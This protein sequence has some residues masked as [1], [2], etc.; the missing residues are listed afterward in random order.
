MTKY[1]FYV[2]FL[3][4]IKNIICNNDN[5]SIHIFN[6][7]LNS[8]FI[9]SIIDEEKNLYIMTGESFNSNVKEQNKI[10]KR[11]ILKYDSNLD[12]IVNNSFLSNF[13]YDISEIISF[14]NT[15][16]LISTSSS[17]EL[18]DI[19]N[20]SIV[21][22]ISINNLLGKRTYLKLLKDNIYLF[23][24]IEN[25]NN[26]K[27]LM[28]NYITL[29]LNNKT[30]NTNKINTN[31]KTS[32]LVL[33]CDTTKESQYIFCVYI[34]ENY[35]LE[36][37]SF[38]IQYQ[39]R[40][41]KKLEDKNK[42]NESNFIKIVYLKEPN[43]FII[44][45]SI[46]ETY[47]RL[48]YFKYKDN[49]FLN[50]LSFIT[51]NENDFLDENLTQLSSY[52]Y[53]NDIITIN[54]S[55]IFKISS[56]SNM[57]RISIYQFDNDDLL[58]SIKTYNYKDYNLV[59]FKNI[60]LS[61]FNNIILV[62]F[63][64]LISNEEKTGYFFI[65]YPKLK[66]FNITDKND[67]IPINKLI[68]I[69]NNLFKFNPKI[70]IIQIPEGF[71]LNNSFNEEIKNGSYLE[72]NDSIKFIEYKKIKNNFN[73]TNNIYNLKFE[74]I[75]K[76][77]ISNSDKEEIYPINSKKIM[78]DSEIIIN[79][80]EGTLRINI[81]E[82]NNKIYPI[83]GIDDVCTKIKRSGYYLDLN[84]NKFMKCY[85][86]CQECTGQYND[87]N[88][89]C[90]ICKI[91]YIM[92]SDKNSCYSETPDNYYLDNENNI[93]KRCHESCLRCF[94]D[95]N[96]SCTKCH[97]DFKLMISNYSCVNIT[98]ES[99]VI[100]KKE[101]LSFSLIFITIFIISIII[102]LILVIRPLHAIEIEVS[103]YSFLGNKDENVNEKEKI[104][105]SKELEMNILGFDVY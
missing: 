2:F 100:H 9:N 45:Y 36:A 68:S 64:T 61:I 26:R 20:N 31:I 90:E 103:R 85:K 54:S 55:K 1:N 58:L 87:N 5:Y 92:T 41:I 47:S 98:D 104:K 83:D 69:E 49:K 66:D 15:Y 78:K 94:S 53:N 56:N 44:I 82:C 11:N 28:V 95:T 13:K 19:K 75:T 12:I 40:T 81:S 105:D 88:H 3:F 43:K 52:Q 59:Y 62:S 63:S 48:R 67:E 30:L 38:S 10:F 101:N 91:N 18:Y 89:N 21:Y 51:D 86:T 29:N 102:G 34:N 84:E 39:N 14:N 71:I 77:N 8:N 50:Q 97:K 99:L 16:I 96:I 25:I 22:N 7:I 74:I 4:L 6:N 72:Y 70:K 57:L 93:Y 65:S 33:S 24:Y 80:K 76:G 27:N 23:T 17:I 35:E 46:N 60:R 37:S 42:I 73:V 32:Q 79:G